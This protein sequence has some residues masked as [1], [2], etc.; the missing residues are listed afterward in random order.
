ML[1][2]MMVTVCTIRVFL[3]LHKGPVFI[4]FKLQVVEFRMFILPS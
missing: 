2:I 3:V 1:I 4:T